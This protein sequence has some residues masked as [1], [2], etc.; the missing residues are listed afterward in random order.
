MTIKTLRGLKKKW[1]YLY[2][3]LLTV[4]ARSLLEDAAGVPG[5]LGDAARDFLAAKNRYEVALRNLEKG[6]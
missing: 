1:K 4:A 3:P 6:T 2:K 5:E